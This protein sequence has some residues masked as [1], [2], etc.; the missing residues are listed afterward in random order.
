MKPALHTVVLVLL[1]LCACDTGPSC[2]PGTVLEGDL[3]VPVGGSDGGPLDAGPG[4]DAGTEDAAGAD[5]AID[6]GDRPDASPTCVS[7]DV[8]VC[9]GDTIVDC[10]T[11]DR[12]PCSAREDCLVLV[13]EGAREGFCAPAGSTPCD[14]ETYASHCDGDVLTSCLR[15]VEADGSVQPGWVI[16]DD[17]ADSAP[18][19]V[20]EESGTPACVSTACDGSFVPYCDPAGRS[21]NCRDGRQVYEDC[22]G[23]FVCAVDR[24]T[25]TLGCVIAG[26]VE[27][28]RAS[29][30]PEVMGCVGGD[31]IIQRHGYQWR[32]PCEETVT[33]VDGEFVTVPTSCVERD[34]SFECLPAARYRADCEGAGWSCDARGNAIYCDDGTAERFDCGSLPCDPDTS[35]CVD[36]TECDPD[37]A[38]GQCVDTIRAITCEDVN[39]D[40]VYWWSL[41]SCPGCSESPFTCG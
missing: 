22:G 40:G 8:S 27:S 7:G 3:C 4:D 15:F 37:T 26:A 18:M 34:G 30:N 23:D 25:S 10:A 20:C 38:T 13:R 6:T 11:E 19:G 41:T 32:Q 36:P 24:I 12:T 21:V 33:R 31:A 14:S 1:A 35:R 16:T 17:C 5:A 28:D 9:D 2:G 39:E 29:T